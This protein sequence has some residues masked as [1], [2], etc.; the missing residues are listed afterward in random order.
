MTG[1][2]GSER[3]WEQTRMLWF[4][5]LLSCLIV[6]FSVGIGYLAGNKY[7]SLIHI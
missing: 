3:Y 2:E 7:L 6:A 4:K 1:L 5:I